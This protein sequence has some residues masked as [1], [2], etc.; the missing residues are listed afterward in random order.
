M[1][2]REKSQ[3]PST[4]TTH[5]SARARAS[6]RTPGRQESRG[7]K[8]AEEPPVLMGL[9]DTLGNAAVVQMLRAAG[10]LGEEDVNRRTAGHGDGGTGLPAVQRSA[11]H[12]VLGRAGR[13]L[14]DAT[15][16]D[17]EAR[18]GADFSDVRVHRG[19]V[20]RASAAEI[21]ARAYTSGSHV[22]IGAGG[23]DRHTLAHE[24]THV[25]Q[26][27]T[28]PVAGTDNGAGL[29]VSEPSDRFEREAEATARRVMSS[30]PAVQRV[31]LDGPRKRAG[32]GTAVQR[33]NDSENRPWINHADAADDWFA[34][35]AAAVRADGLVLSGHGG[36]DRV[37]GYFRV[38]RGT[39]VHFYTVHGQ[40]VPDDLGGQVERGTEQRGSV[41]QGRQAGASRTVVGGR[42]VANYR[43]SYPSGL[44]IRGNPVVAT[45]VAGGYSVEI[46]PGTP[47]PR[48]I[49]VATLLDPQLAGHSIVFDGNVLLSDILQA[50]MGDVHFA[51]CRFVETGRPDTRNQDEG[52]FNP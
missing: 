2:A 12:E 20:A 43:I 25:I 9:Q 1:R 41:E 16:A 40:T 6:S 13:P 17:M 38:P 18:L 14:D 29:R 46:D 34:D 27:R 37:D 5:A 33:A 45:P 32:E 30:G 10:H 51:A 19:A 28:G 26:Q 3:D 42:S 35:N 15:R 21:G 36:W 24:L 44:T 22:V 7:A 39:R 31:T 49:N 50:D 47:A 48:F 11:V 52:L 23:G 4:G 8:E